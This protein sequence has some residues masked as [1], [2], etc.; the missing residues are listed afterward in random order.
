[1]LVDSGLVALEPD[2]HGGMRQASFTSSSRKLKE[3]GIP[4]AEIHKGF[5]ESPGPLSLGSLR[6]DCPFI[7]VGPAGDTSFG[8][9][10]IDGLISHAFLKRYAWT[11]DFD[12]RN[13]RFAVR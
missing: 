8:G 10:R 4:D 9:I 12:T 13:Y 5:F 6:E 7:V 2:G 3:W 1:M 11:V